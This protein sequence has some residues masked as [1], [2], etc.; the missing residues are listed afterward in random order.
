MALYARMS[1]EELL[2][3]RDALLEQY[4]RDRP[5]FIRE[6]RNIIDHESTEIWKALVAIYGHCPAGKLWHDDAEKTLV[7]KLHMT[8][9]T[10]NIR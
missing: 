2:E 10:S 3:A 6:S 4:N 9:Y 8:P 5:A 1:F 7:E